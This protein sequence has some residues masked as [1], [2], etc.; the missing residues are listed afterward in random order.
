MVSAPTTPVSCV[1]EPA[2]SATGVLDELLDTGNP[3]KNPAATLASPRPI[4]SR[5]GSTRS[6]LRPA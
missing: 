3:R 2:D 1:L 6:P 5:F 4:S